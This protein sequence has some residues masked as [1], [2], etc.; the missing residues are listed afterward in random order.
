MPLD[1]LAN[2]AEIIAA[3]VVVVSLIYVAIQIKQNTRSTRLE[4][5]H[6][7]SSGF[8]S[9]YDILASNRE[10]T[11]IWHRGMFSFQGLDETEKLQF[12]FAM[13]RVFR[14]TNEQYFQW[15]EGAVDDDYWQSLSDQFAD[16]TQHPGWQ[17][18]WSRRK[19]H[20]TKDFQNYVDKLIA[21][22]EG[23]EPLYDPPSPAASSG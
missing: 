14:F 3:T 6:A 9:F 1:Q 16:G 10:L 23:R 20:F 21:D 11:N 17:E 22:S 13:M 19:R 12:T 15:R 2:I 7:I 8:N 18:V 4:T 5:V